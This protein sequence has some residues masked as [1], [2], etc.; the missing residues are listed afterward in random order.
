MRRQVAG[1]LAGPLLLGCLLAGGCTGGGAADPHGRPAEDAPAVSAAQSQEIIA[2]WAAR[3]NRAV[4]SGREADWRELTTGALQEVMVE[5]ARVHGGLPDSERIALHNPALYVPRL[6]AHP[7]WFAVAALDDV[8]GPTRQVLVLFQQARPDEPWR[9]AHL[10]EFRGAPPKLSY[11]GQGYAIAATDASLPAGHAG[12]L[13]SGDMTTF[14]PDRFTRR[15]RTAARPSAAPAGWS[16][17]SRFGTG[18]HPS[19]SLR[20]DDGGAL[21]WYSIEQRQTFRAS[22]AARPS[23]LPADLRAYLTRTGRLSATRIQASWTWLAIGYA[24]P[25]GTTHVLGESVHL[26]QVRT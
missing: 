3:Y 25:Q 10:L 7:K 17:T 24:P 12:Y 14:R 8:G 9:A 21:V 18:P 20:T 26:T 4:A 11:D 23:T 2:G 22:G 15:A 5:R 6:P 16:L 1:V 13:S 19:Y